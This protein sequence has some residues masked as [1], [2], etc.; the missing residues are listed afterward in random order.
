M[1]DDKYIPVENS[2]DLVRDVKTNAVINTNRTTFENARKRARDA[3]RQRDEIRDASRE[4]NSLKNEIHEI[5][6]MLKTLLDT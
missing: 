6:S 5:K 3:Q 2:N 4:I 1:R